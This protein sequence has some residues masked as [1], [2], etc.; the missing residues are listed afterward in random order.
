MVPLVPKNLLK[1]STAHSNKQNPGH[2]PKIDG[3]TNV[4]A[5]NANVGQATLSVGLFLFLAI[6]SSEI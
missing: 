5:G 2:H 6:F 1:Q 4:M 3:Q